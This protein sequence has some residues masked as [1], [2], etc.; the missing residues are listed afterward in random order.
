MTNFIQRPLV[1]IAGLT[2]DNYIYDM[3]IS[4]QNNICSSEG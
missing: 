3:F 4:S 2:L 1:N